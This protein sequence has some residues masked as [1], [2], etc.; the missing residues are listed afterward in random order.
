MKSQQFRNVMVVEDDLAL[1]DEVRAVFEK[2]FENVIVAQD[3]A[4]AYLHAYNKELDLIFTDIRMPGMTG[5]ELLRRLRSEG[6]KTPVILSS[7]STDQEYLIQAIRLGIQDFLEKPYTPDGL[8]SLLY[9]NLEIIRR[10]KNLDK[11][12]EGGDANKKE[13]EQQKRMIGLLKAVNA[14]KRAS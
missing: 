7:A 14:T 12:K 3:G 5:I 4:E 2:E 6:I 11:A 13:V 1:L 8:Q 9:R 10:E